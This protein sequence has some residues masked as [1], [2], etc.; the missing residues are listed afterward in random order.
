MTD[1]FHMT[2]EE[3]RRRGREVVDWV[4]DYMEQVGDLPIMSHVAPGDI[5]GR[6]PSTAPEAP[7]SFDALLTDLDDV[8]MPGITH[9]QSP[10]WFAYFPANVSGP[11]IL[12]ELASAGIGAQ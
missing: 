3:F 8:V 10:G 4:A 11:S 5:A 6:L 7:E 1:D 2:A 12:A 9:W